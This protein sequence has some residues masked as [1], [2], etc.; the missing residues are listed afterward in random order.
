M[1]EYRLVD[2]LYL[3]PTAAGAFY[4]VAD[5]DDEPIRRLLIA[6]LRHRTSPL[7]DV[8]RLCQ[9]LEM[10]DRQGALKVLHQAQT[11]S[12]VQGERRPRQVMDF[13]IGRELRDLLPALSSLGKALLVDWNGLSL[14]RCGL[15]DEAAEALSALSADLV[16]VQL[17]HYARLAKSLRL[18]VQGWAAV[19]AYGASRIG[20]W[21]LFVGDERF[22]LVL[23][24]EP[25]LNRQEFV[26]LVW[27]LISRYG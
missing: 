27:M 13:G 18:P 24:G 15:D 23:L 3:L 6:L 9:W 5:R 16:S 26:T 17:R 25:R 2:Q 1:A 4:A 10:T 22:M 11:L 14:A 20:A 21:P 7:A 19:D 8:S 12:L